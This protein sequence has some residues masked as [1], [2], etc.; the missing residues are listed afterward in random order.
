MN[1]YSFDYRRDRRARVWFGIEVCKGGI[2]KHFKQGDILVDVCNPIQSNVLGEVSHPVR[3]WYGSAAQQ[4]RYY[5]PKHVHVVSA[6][7]NVRAT[8]LQDLSKD[9]DCNVF[10]C[11]DDGEAKRKI[12]E[13]AEKIP[14]LRAIDLGP[15]ENSR[16][17]EEFVALMLYLEIRYDTDVHWGLKLKGL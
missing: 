4:A 11:G 15:L 13:L 12:I 16:L 5:T 7:K 3:P 17:V 6:F 2:E 9:V 14:K 8:A 10:V 1:G